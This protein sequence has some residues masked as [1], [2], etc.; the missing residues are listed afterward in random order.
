[1]TKKKVPIEQLPVMPR[2]EIDEVTEPVP[3]PAKPS[4]TE[5]IVECPNCHKAMLEKTFKYYH[6]LKC[7]AQVETDADNP[8][9]RNVVDFNYTRKAEGS[10]YT[11]LFSRAV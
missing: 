4:R 5:K 10:K 11:G 2:E 8:A 7:K 6:N 1:M 3:T 9:Q